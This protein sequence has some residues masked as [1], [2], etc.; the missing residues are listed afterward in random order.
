MLNDM[1]KS[2]DVYV[3][4]SD[5]GST[6]RGHEAQLRTSAGCQSLDAEE[7]CPSLASEMEYSEESNAEYSDA[8]PE[9]SPRSPSVTETL[10]DTD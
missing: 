10:F 1:G 7:S 2:F 9:Y 6:D 3:Y 4:F 5:G 8:T